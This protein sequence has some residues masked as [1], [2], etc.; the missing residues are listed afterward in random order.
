MTRQTLE[1][2]EGIRELTLDQGRELLNRQ[3]QRYLHMTG[4]QFIAAW[5]RGDFNGK[6]DSPEVMRVAMLLP[7]AE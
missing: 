7:L 2:N 6:S 4:E 3:A 1:A 5:R